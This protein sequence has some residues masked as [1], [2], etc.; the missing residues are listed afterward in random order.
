MDARH[1][2]LRLIQNK[3]TPLLTD[4]IAHSFFNLPIFELQSLNP[5]KLPYIVRY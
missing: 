3:K 2:T 1:T 4:V 5:R